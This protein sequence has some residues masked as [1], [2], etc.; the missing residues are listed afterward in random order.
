MAETVS[1][2]IFTQ[3]LVYAACSRAAYENSPLQSFSGSCN[4]LLGV[5]MRQS[6]GKKFPNAAQARFLIG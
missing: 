2:H 3:Y 4:A 6:I 5:R 1:S